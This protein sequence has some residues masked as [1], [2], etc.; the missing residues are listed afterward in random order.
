MVVPL[1]RSAAPIAAFTAIGRR[2][3]KACTAEGW[4]QRP[5]RSGGRRAAAILFR[6]AK[7]GNRGP[8][9]SDP[10]CEIPAAENSR[11]TPL[12]ARTACRPIALWKARGRGPSGKAG[13]ART[14]A[15]D[16]SENELGVIRTRAR[17]SSSGTG[18]HLPRQAGGAR[19]R[20]DD[21]RQGG[22]GLH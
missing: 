19:P 13:S 8:R 10:W 9:E 20:E 16:R 17:P 2:A 3:D 18:A 11:R 22:G 14:N 7:P 6:D 15:I 1:L 12:W 21:R 5:K 4:R